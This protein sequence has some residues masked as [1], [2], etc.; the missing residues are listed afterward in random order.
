[1]IK[2]HWQDL[3]QRALSIQVGKVLPAMLVQKLGT[4]NRRKNL[5]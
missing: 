1:L 5:P 3:I 4:H 2:A